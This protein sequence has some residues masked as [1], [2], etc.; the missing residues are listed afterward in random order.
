MG[1]IISKPGRNNSA[2]LIL[3]ATII[4]L[5]A[6]MFAE[7]LLN[8]LLMA[9]FISIICAQPIVWL[10]K[11]KLADGLAVTLVILLILAIY[12]G[13]IEMVSASISMFINDAPK[14]QES[15]KEMQDS[16][17]HLLVSKGINLA[18]FS[19]SGSMDPS[20]VMQ[21]T[22]KLF[23]RLSEI[24]SKEIT[25]IFLTI[26][27]LA[28]IKSIG[29][30][31]KVIAK[32]TNLKQEYI[33]TIGNSIRHYLSIKTATSFITGV[34]VGISLALIGVDYPILWALVAFLLNYIPTIG[35]VIAA[36][37]AVLISIIQLGFPASFLTIGAYLVINVFIGN[38]VE[39]KIMGKGLGLST[40]IV[41]F[42]LIFWGFIL[43]PVGMFLSVP[44]TM[45]IKI[46]L[47]Y[48]PKTKWV[49]SLLGTEKDANALL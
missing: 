40:F 24:M 4:I 16:A 48:N 21:Y 10:K 33:N 9:F 47:E 34:L 22:S 31:M 13:L 30:K 15:F 3:A 46:I 44:L 37:P 6:A 12:V 14:Y 1:E 25:L 7:S 27:L 42:G 35:S 29:L 5:T 28:E 8:P 45:T 32:Y 36:I 19:E 20:R 26:F 18:I 17:N 23:G 2:P 41:F 11:R 39:P 38:V 49:A 43:G